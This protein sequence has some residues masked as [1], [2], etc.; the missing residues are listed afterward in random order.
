M[1]PLRLIDVQIDVPP[2]PRLAFIRSGS[3]MWVGNSRGATMLKTFYEQL[4]WLIPG[5]DRSEPIEGELYVRIA[6]WKWGPGDIDNLQKSVLDALTR[7]RVWQ[8]DRQV[9]V[10]D[11]VLL[12][13]G[14]GDQVGRLVIEI[15]PKQAATAWWHEYEGAVA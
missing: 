12:P 3:K 8:D 9:K 6:V 4:G 10:L 2:Y 11:G 13:A 5:K 1:K 14:A 7:N 15:Y